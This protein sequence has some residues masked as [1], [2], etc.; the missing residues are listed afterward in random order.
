[1]E[2]SIR[3]MD[4][5]RAAFVRHVGP[6]Q[7]VGPT[8]GRL[9]AWAGRLGLF[10]PNT[11]MFGLCHDDPQVTPTDK[12]RYDACI[13]VGE[14]IQAEGEVGVQTIPAGEYAVAIHHG[15]YD[16]LAQTYAQLCGEWIPQ[17]GREMRSA[18]TIEMYKNDPNRTP[19]EE[20]LTEVY[21]PLE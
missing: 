1:M 18:P 9:C 19:P 14:G 8:W 15:P 5:L 6:Y 21:V 10:G 3:K 11:V 2:A 7:E 4:E 20:L 17:Q 16:G 13:V 12:I